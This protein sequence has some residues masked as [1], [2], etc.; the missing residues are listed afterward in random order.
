MSATAHGVAYMRSLEILFD[1]EER[2][3][4]DP[5]AVALGGEVGR[6]FVEEKH[7]KPTKGMINGISV[8]TKRIDDEF[9]SS[10]LKQI[11]VFGAG[12]DTRPWRLTKTVH[13]PVRYFEIDFP[14]VLAFKLSTLNEMNALSAFDYRSV[15]TDLSVSDWSDKL[16]ASGFEPNVPTFFILEGFVNY[17][18]FEEVASFFTLL[19]TKIAAKGSRLVMTCATPITQSSVKM[20]NLHKFFPEQPLEFF[21]QFGWTGKQEL[22]EEL[23]VSYNRPLDQTN[24]LKGY[25]ILSLILE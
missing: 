15:P 22:V 18:T 20:H 24:N 5:Y 3:F 10:I 2:L 21:S 1:P 9:E 8:R 6:N 17:L 12:L 7:G 13:E 19:S 4:Q 16:L 23:A 25:Y 11:C 14:E